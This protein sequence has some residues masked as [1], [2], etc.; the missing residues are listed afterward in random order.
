MFSSGIYKNRLYKILIT[1]GTIVIT[2]LAVLS[3]SYLHLRQKESGYIHNLSKLHGGAGSQFQYC[4]ES[5]F[6]GS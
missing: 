6:T 2:L 4:H 5:D 3:G 1:T